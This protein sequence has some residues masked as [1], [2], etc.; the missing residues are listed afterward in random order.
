MDRYWFHSQ[1]ANVV[2]IAERRIWPPKMPE[3]LDTQT[4][5]TPLVFRGG[6]F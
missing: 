4:G 1:D 3:R 6:I 5:L 2:G